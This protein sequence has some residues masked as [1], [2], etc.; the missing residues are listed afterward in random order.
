ML[1]ILSG[2]K[3]FAETSSSDSLDEFSQGSTGVFDAFNASPIISGEGQTQTQFFVDG[4]HS[5]VRKHTD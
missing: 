4:N 2:L 5:K 3:K 1:T